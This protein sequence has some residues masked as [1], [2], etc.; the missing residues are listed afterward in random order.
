VIANSYG[1]DDKMARHTFY[2]NQSQVS[3][4][5]NRKLSCH[6]TRNHNLV[7]QATAKRMAKFDW[8]QQN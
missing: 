3:S 1:D 6:I 7:K 4:A 2:A 5:P 8:G